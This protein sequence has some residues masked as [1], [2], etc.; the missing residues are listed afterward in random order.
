MVEAVFDCAHQLFGLKFTHRPDLVTYHPDVKTYEVRETVNGQDRFVGLFLHD[1]FLRQ[2][3]KSGAWM[4]DYRSQSRTGSADGSSVT[5]IIVN[6][7]NFAKGAEGQP[8]LISLDDATTLFHEFGHGMH[9]MLSDV[10]YERLAGTSVLRDFVELPS[11]LFEHWLTQPVVLKKWA[12]HY[13]TGEPIPDELLKRVLAAKCFNK[14]FETVEYTIS[15]L[16]DQSLHK[17]SL[18]EIRGLDL[19][20]F[21]QKELTRL[22]MPKGIIMRHRPAHF[23]HLFSGSSYAAAYY[24]YLWA[25]V[26]DADGFEAFIERGDPFDPETARRVR[27]FIYSS[28]NSM[29]P[30]EAYRAF[31]GRD[32]AVEPM[33]KKKGL[34]TSA[35]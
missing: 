14:G 6:N 34:L 15:A 17:L 27:Q 3:K 8:T 31:R 26:L 19:N 10:T 7:N 2:H 5:P 11:Q 25:E 33:L 9:G 35:N 30:R 1:N 18:D 21:E 23:S 29:D 22:G 13:Q 28:G 20:A 16:I 32:P 12:R 24:V 4:S